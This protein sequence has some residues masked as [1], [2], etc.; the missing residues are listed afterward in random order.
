MYEIVD[1][2]QE[3]KYLF[4]VAM[5]QYRILPRLL[6]WVLFLVLAKNLDF[7]TQL[8]PGHVW[9]DS[10]LTIVQIFLMIYLICC[11]IRV[12][13]GALHC[14]SKETIASVLS[15]AFTPSV[16]VS[17][18]FVLV[19]MS[20]LFLLFVGGRF[21]Q[22]IQYYSSSKQ[23][24]IMTH[25]FGLGIY[26]LLVAFTVAYLFIRVLFVVP[27]LVT[28]DLAFI[29]A[30]VLSFEI[31]ARYW[32]RVSVFYGCATFC[33]LLTMHSMYWYYTAGQYHLM[34]LVDYVLF[35]VLF[36]AFGPT[37]LLLLQDLMRRHQL[38][39]NGTN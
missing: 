24:Q 15:K 21:E 32:L 39:E 6:I 9:L 23:A 1:S 8:F 29:D 14:Y 16:K 28:Q 20:V 4:K 7:I 2:P 35:S 27:L 37:L 17:F 33:G 5:R 3:L 34:L 11:L 13:D 19:V 26:S 30:I 31:T 22:L 38:S 25:S 36:Y 12:I 10:S 18:F